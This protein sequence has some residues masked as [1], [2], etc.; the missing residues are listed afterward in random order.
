V[1][2]WGD[3]CGRAG[4]PNIFARVASFSDWIKETI[5]ANGARAIPL[6]PCR[7]NRSVA[8]TRSGLALACSLSLFAMASAFVSAW[9]EEDVEMIVGGTPAPE[10]KYP[11]Q[12]RLYDP[13]EDDK[14]FCGGSIVD[15]QWVLTPTVCTPGEAIASAPSNRVKW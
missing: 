9:A 4:N 2:S 10:G 12:A 8:M 15:A 11:Y 7:Q 5:N 14:G 1:V 6:P 13:V 3:R